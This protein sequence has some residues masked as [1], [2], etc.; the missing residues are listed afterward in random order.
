MV[1]LQFTLEWSDMAWRLGAAAAAGVLIG[2]NRG[3]RGKAA[4]LRTTLLVILAAALAMILGN[5]LIPT[6]GKA[7][8]SFVQLDMMRLPL[9]I[10]TGIG[11]IGAGTILKKSDLIIGVT[12]AATIWYVSVLGLCFGAGQF[13]LGAAGTILALI[14]LA[15]LAWIEPILKQEQR[16]ILEIVIE[17][18]DR[19][20]PIPSSEGEL[21]ALIQSSGRRIVS[22]DTDVERV[23]DQLFRRRFVL[24][25]R[26]QARRRHNLTPVFLKDLE[27][28][29]GVT[30]V[31]WQ[32]IPTS[33]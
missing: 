20:L 32:V 3:E 27:S 11:F 18:G 16:A 17:S 4:G 33:G 22:C 25:L 9:G 7:A 5:L 13:A 1:G 8:D 28:R 12:T 24:E 15:G 10:L 14:V 19:S 23:G 2:L 30:R 29:P 6:H 21:R 31:T 26:W